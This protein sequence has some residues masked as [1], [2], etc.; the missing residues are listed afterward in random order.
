[1]EILGWDMSPERSLSRICS[2]LSQ[3]TRSS[4]GACS[5][6]EESRDHT[7]V[8][9]FV[10]IA[11]KTIKNLLILFKREVPYALEMVSFIVIVDFFCDVQG[12]EH[13]CSQ[14]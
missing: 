3:E 1:M 14:R 13:H 10:V 5:T 6:G 7:F 11:L 2:R 12:V 4:E 9:I 8:D